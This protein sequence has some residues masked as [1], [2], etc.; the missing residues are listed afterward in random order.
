MI[1]SLFQNLKKAKTVKEIFGALSGD[2]S[3]QLEEL[4][5]QYRKFVKRIH[6]DSVPDSEKTLATEAFQI[7]NQ[8]YEQAQQEIQSG[9]YGQTKSIKIKNK[10]KNYILGAEFSQGDVSTL[11]SCLVEGESGEYLIKMSDGGESNPL[12]LNEAR[13]Y[14]KLQE[15][16]DEALRKVISNHTGKLVE[17]FEG[18]NRQMNVL[19]KYEK[20]YTLEQVHKAFGDSLHPRNIAWIL[21]RCFGALVGI[22]GAGLVHGAFLPPHFLIFETDHNG[23][24]IDFCYSVNKGEVVK[25]ISPEWQEFYAPEILEKKPVDEATDIFMVAKTIS[26]LAGDLP[27]QL[28]NYL[29]SLMI[30]SQKSRE[31]DALLIYK[32]LGELYE[33]I[34]GKPVFWEFKMP[35]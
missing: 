34:W 27:K 17:S 31:H 18:N 7:L 21:R 11:Y 24:A 6:P 5:D 14:K 29:R 35:T 1:D 8:K 3:A 19:E 10:T 33:E 9:I 23:R 15:V 2:K 13:A 26:Y 28:Q 4:K 25:Y 32:E 30:K 22:H 16:K 20:G 12:L